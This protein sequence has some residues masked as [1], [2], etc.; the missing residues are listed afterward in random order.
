MFSGI[1][2]S[3]KYLSSWGAGHLLFSEGML[4]AR[5]R[6]LPWEASGLLGAEQA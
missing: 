1:L 3:K 5:R 2:E 6:L 4:W